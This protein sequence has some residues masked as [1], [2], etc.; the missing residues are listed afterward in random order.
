MF[1]FRT[2]ILECVPGRKGQST[3]ELALLL[4]TIVLMLSFIIYAYKVN[5]EVSQQTHDTYSEKISKFHLEGMIFDPVKGIYVPEGQYSELIA[6]DALIDP[7]KLV[8]ELALQLVAQLGL[9][10]LF[11][12]LNIDTSTYGGAFA[13]GFT[14]SLASSAISTGVQTG[15][16]HDMNAQ[17][18]ENATWAGGAA[19]FNS[20]SATEDFQGGEGVTAGTETGLQEFLG[21][22]AQAGIVGFFNSHGD[23]AVAGAS[24]VGGA[25]NSDT[26]NEWVDVGADGKNDSA[27]AEI[28]RGATK[29]AVQGSASGLIGGNLD[30]KTVVI[31]AASGAVQTQAFAETLP[32]TGESNQKESAMYGAFN[33]AFASTV[34]GG[35]GTDI[36]YSAAGGAL[37]S[38]Q[39]AGALGGDRSFSYHAASVAGNAG[40]QYA[41][42]SSLQAVGIGALTS[43]VSSGIGY[44]VDSV[45]GSLSKSFDGNGSNKSTGGNNDATTSNNKTMSPQDAQLVLNDQGTADNL[46]EDEIFTEDIDGILDGTVA[47]VQNGETLASLEPEE[48]PSP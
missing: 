44:G 39:T 24:A 28:L 6:P 16:L 10:K 37:S 40:L 4:P 43:S 26:S 33:G 11:S 36:L 2:K 47:G 7:G 38:K 5:H 32:L 34:S 18:L 31:G 30:G 42:G 46:A 17:D 14:S 19:A 45:S 3:V 9:N 25:L 1:R 23:F 35:S 13:Q 22:G 48:V 12:A 27:G 41:S 8:G 29:G 20:Q 15:S 21:S